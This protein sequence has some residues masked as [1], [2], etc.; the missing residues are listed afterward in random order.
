[1]VRKAQFSREDVVKA[2][3]SVVKKTGVL[4][5]SARNVAQELGSSTAPVYSNFASMEELETEVFQLAG[6]KFLE[7]AR[8]R[9]TDNPFLNMGI[10]VLRFARECPRWYHAMST[11]EHVCL[12]SM[13][14]VMD[15]LA[16]DLDR[17]DYLQELDPR[18]R[19]L[20]LHK[21]GTFT[22][23]LAWDICVRRISDEEMEGVVLLLEEVG[24][25]LTQS[26][27]LHPARSDEEYSKLS[28]YFEFMHQCGPGEALTQQKDED[29]D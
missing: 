13:Q 15:S 23:G 17:V 19:R 25:A 20:L 14:N 8:G 18:E 10:G 21:M 24:G 1:M 5:L 4:R 26:A 2:A 9:Y 28:R 16:Q 7:F 27:I 3:F 6:A 22:H 12:H 11:Q 29:H